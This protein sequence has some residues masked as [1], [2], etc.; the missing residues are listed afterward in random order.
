MRKS[1]RK[2]R[3]KKRN[4]ETDEGSTKKK[5]MKEIIKRMEKDVEEKYRDIGKSRQGIE[6]NSESRAE[7]RENG[8]WLKQNK[9]EF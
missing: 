9:K 1:G 7:Q 6:K 4:T 3:G 8:L 5:R 2:L